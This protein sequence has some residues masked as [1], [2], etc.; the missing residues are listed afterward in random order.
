MTGKELQ[1]WRRKWGLTQEKLALCLG[2]NRITIT[3]WETGVRPIPSFLFLALEALENRIKEVGKDG[4]IS[5][6]SR[7]QAEEKL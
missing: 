3:R 2:V 4:I 1:A 5:G 7:V 6:M